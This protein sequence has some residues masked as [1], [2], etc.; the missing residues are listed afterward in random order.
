MAESFAIKGLCLQK[1]KST[2]TKYKKAEKDDE[3]LRCYEL[4][5][6]LGLLY[7]QELDKQQT[8]TFTN[9]GKYES[10]LTVRKLR[11]NFRLIFPTT[12]SKHQSL[13]YCIR[14]CYA[15]SSTGIDTFE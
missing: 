1:H 6:D 2:T 14:S 12:I 9:T 4:A 15:S 10:M 5:T 13:K 11:N 3:M 7:M 8:S